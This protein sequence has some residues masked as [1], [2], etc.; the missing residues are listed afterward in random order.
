MT[1]AHFHLEQQ[2]VVIGLQRAELGGPLRRLPVLHSRVVE[3]AG[4][5]HVRVVLGLDVVVRRIGAHV[6]VELGLV[7]IAP[8]LPLGHG[9]R[10]SL[11]HHRIHHVHEGDLGHDHAEEAGIHVDHG[12]HQQSAGA[13]APDD[14]PSRLGVAAG[15]Q[16][17]RA[18]DEIGERV[19]LVEQFA[20]LVPRAPQG[21]AAPDVGDG[22]D[23][24]PVEQ[25]QT[26]GVEVRFDGCAVGAVAVE[27][28]RVLA[29]ASDAGAVDQ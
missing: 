20:V 18:G 16:V 24:S 28:Q 8:L 11:V 12:P 21:A 25:A 14:Q 6:V 9:Q 1:G 17:L 26:R 27:Q 7:R 23:E 10:K 5:Q 15:D 19:A 2:H 4:D 3:P 22:V 29:V 13:T